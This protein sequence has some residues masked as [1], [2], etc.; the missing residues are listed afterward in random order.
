MAIT[1]SGSLSEWLFHGGRHEKAV[2]KTP[3]APRPPRPSRLAVEFLTYAVD[4]C[5]QVVPLVRGRSVADKILRTRRAE[6]R[7]IRLQPGRPAAKSP[8]PSR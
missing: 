6:P 7:W 3:S 2:E 5:G 8:T 4:A 1:F